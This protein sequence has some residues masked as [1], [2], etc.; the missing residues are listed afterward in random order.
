M[1]AQQLQVANL[2]TQTDIEPSSLL[3]DS[4]INVYLISAH[5]EYA[6]SDIEIRFFKYGAGFAFLVIKWIFLPS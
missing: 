3:T 4:A 1:I 5:N 6:D 2:S